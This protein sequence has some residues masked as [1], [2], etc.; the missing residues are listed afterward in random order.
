MKGARAAGMAEKQ[1]Q[2][3]LLVQ[4]CAQAAQT[5]GELGNRCELG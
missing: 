3:E 5:S 1:A 4:L 2:C